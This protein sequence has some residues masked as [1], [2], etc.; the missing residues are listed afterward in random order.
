M[1]AIHRRLNHAG[2]APVGKPTIFA[3]V[4]AGV[5]FIAAEE[6]AVKASTK[7]TKNTTAVS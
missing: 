1:K 2:I 5:Y 6:L 7:Y 4:V 3:T